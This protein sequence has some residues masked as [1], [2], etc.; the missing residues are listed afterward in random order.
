[1]SISAFIPKAHTPFQWE[2]FVGTV[3][4]ER[5]Y[6]VLR[7]ELRD[8]SIELS[9]RDVRVAQ[10][11]AVFARGDRRLGA[12][13]HA[14]WRHGARFDAWSSEINWTAWGSAWRETG[15]DPDIFTRGWS[16]RGR[17]LPWGHIDTGISEEFL[18]CE[19]DRSMRGELW[20]CGGSACAGCLGCVYGKV[21]D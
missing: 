3:E 21:Q 6:D 11:E 16:E 14:A 15:L 5:R 20:R 4:L 7:K 13:V 1:M 8:R 10:L 12:L 17:P 9:W 2:D 19:R 18:Q